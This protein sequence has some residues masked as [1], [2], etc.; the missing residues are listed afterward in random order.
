[1]AEPDDVDAR[2][3]A[4]IDAE[5]GAAL[6]VDDADIDP[7]DAEVVPPRPVIP[8]SAL[9]TPRS[10]TPPEEPDEPFV[11]PPVAPAPPLSTP[12]LGAVVLLVAATVIG[13]LMVARVS[14]P[15]WVQAAGLVCFFAGAAL[16][17]SRLPRDRR[18]DPDDGAV[19]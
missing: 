2:F 7:D 16:A 11:P 1:M 6:P 13:I 12:A 14:L 17:F 18:Q 5:Y 8:F 15:W 19:V 4:L 9:P 10:W 3:R